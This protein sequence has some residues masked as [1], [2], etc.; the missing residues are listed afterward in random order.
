MRTEKM[1]KPNEIFYALKEFKYSGREYIRGDKFPSRDMTNKQ[2]L[3]FFQNGF[4]GYSSD[5]K[6]NKTSMTEVEYEDKNVTSAE[7]EPKEDIAKVVEDTE[8]SFKVEYQ[9]KVR[10]I[11]RNQYREDGTLTKGGLKAFKD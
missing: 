5:F 8:E 10:E 1:F 6:Y 3:K 2:L 11:S 9:G 4:V 7:E